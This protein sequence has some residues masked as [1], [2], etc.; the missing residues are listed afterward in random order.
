[1]DSPIT[2]AEV[3]AQWIETKRKIVKHSS[4]CAY[5]LSINTH[6]LPVFGSCV[7]IPEA[8][9]QQFLFDKLESGLSR[10]T[11]KGV[12]ALLKNIVRYGEKHYG[13][14]GETWDI[15]FPRSTARKK[16][17]VLAVAHHRKL[18]KYLSENLTDLNVGIFLSLC[19]GMRIGEVCALRW[20]DVDLRG[21]TITISYTTG[22]I[23]NYERQASEL[24][25]STPKTLCSNR[26][27][28]I[29]R[30]LYEGLRRLKTKD[31]DD[32]YFVVG[33]SAAPKSPRNYR[34]IFARLLKRLGI[35]QVVFH[36]LRH[37]FATRCIECGCDIKTVSAIL[38][39]SNVATT[40]NLYV[41]PNQDHKRKC[42][43]RL[44]KFIGGN[45]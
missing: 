38:G 36:G 43:D 18:M 24:V 2:F 35:P 39:H 44:S 19:T 12:I 17:P 22:V 30:E 32:D 9:V 15:T 13:Y 37:T 11:V 40:M 34:E 25:L 16:L 6:L 7:S 23:Y 28:P 29:G 33:N 8:D 5:I 26:E 3:S 4:M 27:I 45:N 21:R 10:A 31:T 14:P 41:H 20:R 1:M 42:M